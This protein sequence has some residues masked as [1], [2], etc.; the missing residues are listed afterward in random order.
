MTNMNQTQLAVTTVN[1]LLN[2]DSSEP[3]A[4]I[5]NQIWDFASQLARDVLEHNPH[6]SEHPMQVTI[7]QAVIDLNLILSNGAL[8]DIV[9]AASDIVADGTISSNGR[10]D[11]V[12]PKERFQIR[13]QVLLLL[14]KRSIAAREALLHENPELGNLS[15]E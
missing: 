5:T 15:F 4:S 7:K 9:P 6:A 11:A 1:S 2:L 13:S 3:D 14:L 10:V 12:N 8:Y